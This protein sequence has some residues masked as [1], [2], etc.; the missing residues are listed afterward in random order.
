MLDCPWNVHCWKDVPF[1]R[2]AIVLVHGESTDFPRSLGG[3]Q[4][5]SEPWRAFL[6]AGGWTE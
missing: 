2:A 4:T 1:S 6:G 3:L 5:V